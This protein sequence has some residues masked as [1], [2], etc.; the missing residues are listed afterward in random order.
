MLSEKINF[1]ELKLA[2]EVLLLAKLRLKKLFGKKRKNLENVLVVDTCIIGEFLATLPALSH[3]IKINKLNVD[4]VVSP[5]TKSLAEKIKGVNRIFTAKSV[6]GRGLEK[7]GKNTDI[8]SKYG[9]IVVLRISQDAYKLIK[10]VEYSE[11]I[12]YDVAY[13]KFFFHILKNVLMKKK[14]KQWREVNFEILNSKE[15]KKIIKFEDIFSFKKTDYHKA[16]KMLRSF[17]DGKKVII[18]TGDGWEMKLWNNKNWVKLLQKINKLG[19]FKFIFVGSSKFEENSFS[20]LQ[21]NL[22]FKIYSLIN[23]TD[24]G[25]LLLLMRK[26]NYFI[27]I[28]SGPRNMAHIADLRSVTLLNPA[29]LRDFMPTDKR[30]IA[31]DKP[32]R[33]P[34]SIFNFK[35][36]S[37]TK[38]ISVDEVFHAFKKLK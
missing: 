25:E 3:F 26:S 13:F 5:A 38:A 21:K 18:H 36:L 15:P 10:N 37:L 29:G 33:F 16:E 1:E 30:D 12:I 23:K 34:V 8:L 35:K 14:I 9:L 17:G 19:K 2:K 31:I 32:I 27:G 24:L 6:Y 28:D 11:L 4:M 7:A 20:Y 22:G